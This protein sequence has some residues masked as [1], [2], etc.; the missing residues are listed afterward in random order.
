[1]DILFGNLN[2]RPWGQTLA[3][4]W[5]AEFSGRLTV[6]IATDRFEIAFYRGTIVAASSPYEPDSAVRIAIAAGLVP[7]SR[8]IELRRRIAMAPDRDDV[9]VVAEAL[10]LPVLH[11]TRLRRI[12]LAQR[13]ARTFAFERGEL[14]IEG[15]DPAT[16]AVL[17]GSMLDPRA[18]IYIGARHVLGDRELAAQLRRLG[19]EFRIADRERLELGDFGF[20][21]QL[22]IDAL[23]R[24]CSID[25][26]DHV[27]RA[28]VYALACCGAFDDD[29]AAG[30]EEWS[31]PA[32][33]RT[34]TSHAIRIG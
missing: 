23:E 3:A 24:G 10:H 30:E 17:A 11:A 26:L 29:G 15:R 9:D 1:M 20:T 7:A 18:V 27:E 2:D 13:V 34:P 4:L 33:A 19:G 16:M 8:L 14:V 28:M 32:V 31:A 5:M 6:R 12:V 22:P 21:E 25:E